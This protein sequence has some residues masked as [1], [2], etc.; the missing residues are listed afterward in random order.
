MINPYFDRCEYGNELKPPYSYTLDF[1]I[2]TTYSLSF[3]ALIGVSRSL[4]YG[5]EAENKEIINEVF[6]LSML[7][8]INKNIAV[9][10]ESG[11]IS[12]PKTPSKL[13]FKLEDSIFQVAKERGI[14]HP[15]M[16]YIRYK[17]NQNKYKYKLIILTKNITFNN[18]MDIICTFEGE[19]HNKKNI[20][21]KGLIDFLNYIN[22]YTTNEEKRKKIDI[23]IKELPYIEFIHENFEEMEFIPI[24]IYNKKTNIKDILYNHK[25][26]QQTNTLIMTPF[27]EKKIIND[28]NEISGNKNKNYLITRQ[29]EL[30][31]LDN[32]SCK[33]FKTYVLNEEIVE[34]GDNDLHA[35]MYFIENNHQKNLYIGSLNA[36]NNAFNNNI[37]ILVR[38]KNNN[39]MIHKIAN[40][41]ISPIE[42]ITLFNLIEN[43]DEIKPQEYKEDKQE[44]EIQEIIRIITRSEKKAKIISKNHNYS[45]KIIFNLKNYNFKY[46]PE[47]SLFLINSYK[48]LNNIVTFDNVKIENL[49]M[50]Y[51]IK[52]YSKEFVLKID[53]ENMPLKRDYYIY[54]SIIKNQKD[55]LDYIYNML[56]D[57]GLGEILIKTNSHHSISSNKLNN[58]VLNNLYE[59]LLKNSYDDPE[60][61]KK[62]YNTICELDNNK[63]NNQLKQMIKD[64]YEALL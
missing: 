7:D 55:V 1:A 45:V 6:V 21:N 34:N 41:I 27:L 31:K 49:S 62:I 22:K 57:I 16:W 25:N 50:F 17:N 52:V 15:K 26:N 2:G 4:C 30:L 61:I 53:T 24:G 60:I 13:C 47:I 38:L 37:E 14:F 36:T 54:K 32:K 23:L 12:K 43:I 63:I 35:K 5:L 29:D 44:K 8:K 58:N 3:E 20:K 48:S 10:C 42:K 9:Y 40:S 19:K 11:K 64:F 33:N 18:N 28:F 39:L 51:K 46:A 59:K 56:D